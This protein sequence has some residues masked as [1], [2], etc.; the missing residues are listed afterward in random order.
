MEK[1]N[2][3]LEF[4]KPSPEDYRERSHK[5]DDSPAGCDQPPTQ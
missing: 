1:A 3:A 5:T 2:N 4:I